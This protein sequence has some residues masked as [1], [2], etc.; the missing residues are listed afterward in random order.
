MEL[1][2]KRLKLFH[3]LFRPEQKGGLV[4]KHLVSN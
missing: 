2:L 3:G 1:P 4:R